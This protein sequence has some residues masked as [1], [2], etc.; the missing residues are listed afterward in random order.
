MGLKAIIK[1]PR[2]G[3]AWMGEEAKEEDI[4]NDLMLHAPMDRLSYCIKNAIFLWLL[5]CKNSL[6]AHLL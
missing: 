4:N 2:P 3:A 1:K 6:L 5:N